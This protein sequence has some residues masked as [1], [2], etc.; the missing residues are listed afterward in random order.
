MYTGVLSLP[1]FFLGGGGGGGGEEIG[2]IDSATVTSHPPARYS[3]Q[4]MIYSPFE[5]MAT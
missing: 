2:R 4:G 1:V 3:T 5:K